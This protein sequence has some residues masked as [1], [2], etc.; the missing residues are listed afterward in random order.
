MF[1]QFLE[2]L[3]VRPETWKILEEIGSCTFE[4]GRI[5]KGY[6]NRAPVTQEIRSRVENWDIMKS[7]SFWISK[8]TV[9]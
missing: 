2:D 3:D 7:K 8:G 1:L 9:E 4:G 6:F 5:G